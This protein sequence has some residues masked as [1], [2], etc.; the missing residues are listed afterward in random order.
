MS[1]EIDKSAF[2]NY[3]PN[4]LLFLIE[5]SHSQFD[6]TYYFTNN[7][8]DISIEGDTYEPFP[9]IFNIPAQGETQG[10]SLSLGNIDRRV[11]SEISTTIKSNENILAQIYLCHIEDGTPERFDLGVFE[12][13]TADITKDVAILGVNQRTSLGF[14]VGTI[15]Y[16]QRL[17]PNLY[18]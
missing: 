8:A 1:F 7:N 9:F 10:S 17:F 6:Q 12:V 5:L 2:S 15:R 18:L 13:L 4:V 16:S 14:N 3:T 11:A